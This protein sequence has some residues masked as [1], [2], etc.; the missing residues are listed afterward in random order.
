V[1]NLRRQRVD[2]AVLRVVG[3][4]RRAHEEPKKHGG[5]RRN[6]PERQLDRIAS[7]GREVTLGPLAQCPTEQHGNDEE[8]EYE[9]CDQRHLQ[10]FFL[11]SVWRLL[12]FRG[13]LA[14]APAWEE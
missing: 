9:G 12:A 7:L 10:Q 2:L 1:A 3:A 6:E 13:T 14:L 4:L 8:R 5:H 11:T